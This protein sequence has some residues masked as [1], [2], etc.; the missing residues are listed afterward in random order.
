MSLP[1]AIQLY[2]LSDLTQK[3]FKGTLKAVKEMG[4]D[5]VEFAGLFNNEPSDIKAYLK[6]L[7]LVPISAHVPLDEF[8]Y[9]GIPEVL[10][11][12][13]AIGCD[14]V[15]LPYT[16]EDRRPGAKRFP[17]T[18]QL[19]TYIGKE[20]AQRGMVLLYHN[21][22]FEFK[23]KI[24]GVYGLEV[25][26]NSISPKYLQSELDTCWVNIGGEDPAAYIK[27]FKGR[28]PVVHLKD[29]YM[30]GKL[31]SHLYALIGIDEKESEKEEPTFEFRPIGHG[32][33]DMP[34]ILNASVEAGSKWVVVEQD[35][36]TP[37]M[38]RLECAKQ[39]IDYIKGLKW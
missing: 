11:K 17:E 25:I 21:H 13:K 26:Y 22:D 3:D 6:E 33:Q 8:I 10:D 12:Y 5:G 38:T 7:D 36:P 4:Y 16:V 19:T 30:T 34:A 18:M 31:P 29:F 15:V 28:A 1:V 20:A 23:T 35:D 2:S 37:G 24:D 14:Y 39:S 9:D 27:K 32:M